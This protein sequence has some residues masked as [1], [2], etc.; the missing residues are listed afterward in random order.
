MRKI[1]FLF[2][3]LFSVILVQNGL[4]QNTFA[5]T[6]SFVSV[7]NPIR[8]TDFWEL[9]NQTIEEAFLGEMTILDKYKV[10]A[11]W[12][13]RFDGF[14]NPKII[15]SL[16]S[17]S[18]DETG[19]FLEI[20]P[21]W[22]KASGV[23]YRTSNSWHNAGSA[24]LSGYELSEREKL[25]D[26]AFEKFKAVFGSYPKTVGAWWIDANSISYMSEKYGIDSTLIVA[27]Q[28]TTDNYQ[29]WGQFWSTPYYPAKNNALHPAQS[30]NNKIPVVMIQWAVRDP[31]NAYGNGVTESTFSVQANDYIDYHNLNAGYFEKLVNIYTKPNLNQFGFLV[32]GLENSYEWAKYKSEYENQIKTLA[33]K[34]DKEDLALATVS[35]FADWYKKTYPAIS[36]GHVIAA[37]DPLG[38]YKKAVW[39]MNPYYRAGFFTNQDGAVFRD[40]RQYIDGEEELCFKKRCDAIN[41]ASFA[42]RVLDEV[43]FGHKWL[44]DEGKISDFKVSKIGDRVVITY[45]NVAGRQR[46]IEF[47]DRDI[48]VDGKIYSIDKA[49]LEATK[50]ALELKKT[51]PK[52]APDQ[53]TISWQASIINTVKFL[54]FLILGCLIPGV[55]LTKSFSNDKSPFFQK[56]FLS[57]IVGLSLMTVIFYLIGLLKMN[58]LIYGYLFFNLAVFVI[59]RRNFPFSIGSGINLPISALVIAGTIFQVIPTFQNA[60]T[61][62]FGLGFWGP[63]THDGIW[64][65]SLINQLIKGVPPQNPIFAGEALKNYHFFYDLMVAATSFVSGISPANLI[66]RFYP[67]LFSLSLGIGSYYLIKILFYEKLTKLQFKIASIFGLYLI[68]FAGSFGWIVAYIKE[69]SLSG[70]SAFWANQSVSFNLNPPFAISLI[71]IIA[72]FQLLPKINLKQKKPLLILCLLVGPLIA[73]KA[74]GGILILASLLIYGLLKSSLSHLLIFAAS[75][76]VSASLY[77]LNFTIGTKVLLFSP[78][79]FIHSM[80]D[81]PDRVGWLRLTLARESGTVSG[82]WFKYLSA[83]I[84]GF[85]M[86]LI[87]NLGV[88]FL[89]LFSLLKFNK[90][91]K[92]KAY[93]F[94]LIFTT[95][96]FSIPL[97][98]IQAGNP[99]NTIQF[100]YYSLYI[101]A[102]ISAVVM[103]VFLTKIPKLAG[104]III[105]V[106][107]IITPINSWA[108]ANSYLT[109]R[110]HAYIG[111]GEVK[112]LDFL[113]SQNEGVVLT[114]PFDEKLK[115]KLE[116]PWPLAVYDSTAYVSALSKMPVFVEDQPQNEILLTDYK[117]RIVAVK[118][119]FSTQSEKEN[120]F[121][122]SNNIRYIY[123]AKVHGKRL[124]EQTLH[125]KN[126]FENEDV[127][128]YAM[129]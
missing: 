12:L 101:A 96:G 115:T 117:K 37:D 123:L 56:L 38:S 86:F 20:T 68:Y 127:I 47:L 42:T 3:F 66:F 129:K 22:T 6:A 97:I 113:K 124:D 45:Q 87:G 49:I 103:A 88:R 10:P 18:S 27:D 74:Y 114:Y 54:L 126:I 63:N 64:H 8:G 116:E 21:T 94:L 44:I 55:L 34:K 43:S 89:A 122:E 82:N 108:T 62:S 73:F 110:P 98:F 9:P 80:V 118:D 17:R 70:E 16:K 105:L 111:N 71:I 19:L 95:L 29:I 13:L 76:V 25:I 59:R 106:L 93:L 36:A 83:E 128:I 14:N 15:E 48:S 77:L 65:I 61:H 51:S 104:F 32:V 85:L 67:V 26:S 78:F 39:F 40:I 102:L 1:I 11:T 121:L 99:W 30:I 100:S 24:F 84:I 119:F 5:K 90:I 112:G 92:D 28:Y 4:T 69:K 81:S 33:D 60:L 120:E 41:F 46:K 2:L 57:M 7:V 23:N 50:Q 109:Y 91:L 107:L 35:S 58:F 31:V 125:I 72:I 79:W 52:I 75:S 53:F